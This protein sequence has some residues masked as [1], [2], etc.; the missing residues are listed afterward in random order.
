[1]GIEVSRGRGRPPL[2]PEK[3]RRRLL[4]AA[5]RTFERNNYERASVSDIVR[6]AGMSSRSFYALFDSK[7]D[8]VEALVRD[9]GEIFL[10]QF[11]KA[12]ASADGGA[13][14]LRNVVHAYAELLPVVLLDFERLG[15]TVGERARAARAPFWK[16]ITDVTMH[17]LA[18]LAEAG[19]IS[20]MPERIV[21]ELFL[22]GVEALTL[23]YHREGRREELAT[24]EPQLVSSVLRVFR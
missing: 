20:E 22:V 24:L 12:F 15:G 14:A 6:E 13:G 5:V 4:E 2:P 21:V 16:R 3:Q 9:T 17:Q 19:V 7:E 1:M 10:E 8:L 11:E 18:K 23:R